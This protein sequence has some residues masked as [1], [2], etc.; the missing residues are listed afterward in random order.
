MPQA[1]DIVI[2]DAQATPVNH[3]FVPIGPDPKD[4]T[5]YWWEDQ[6]QASPAGYWRL[7]MQLVRPAPAKAG[8]NT[9][10]RMIRVRVS[11]FEPILEVAVTA[12]YS[13]IAPSPTV[14]Y[15]P[16]AFTE[17][18][19]PERAT[20]DNRKDI[21]KMHALALT[22]SEAIAMIESLQFVY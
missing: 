6:S 13:G 18:V 16:K 8:Q 14:S 12:T 19:L 3:T 1:A 15:V 4:A 20:L 17:F 2:A 21:R 10:Q 5:I 7:S 11:T 9:N 22:T